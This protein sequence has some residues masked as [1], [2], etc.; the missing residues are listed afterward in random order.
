MRSKLSS[1]FTLIET[2]TTLAIIVI[3]AGIVV[4]VAGFV[5]NRSNRARAQGELKMLQTACDNYK[6]DTGGYPQDVAA[7]A[8]TPGVTDIISPKQ[9]FIPTSTEYE[10]SSEYLY[11]QLTGDKGGA[12]GGNPDGVP[13][14]GEP[15]YLK[16]YD[17]NKI[18]MVERDSMTRK[19]KKVKGFQDPWGYYYGYSTAGLFAE[20]EFQRELKTK[21]SAERKTG[22]DLLG[23]N[24][25]SFDMWCTAGSKPTSNP[26]S[27][28]LRN[29]EHGKWE[30]NW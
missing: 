19:I 2:I 26:T 30:K 25:S 13:D 10:K 5:N 7:T 20:A 17:Q 1:A 9:H 29:Q 15:A 28:Q 23:F 14:D 12:S 4:G 11:K 24:T 18:L 27:P 3:L 16:G 22:D 8:S 6:A 21:P